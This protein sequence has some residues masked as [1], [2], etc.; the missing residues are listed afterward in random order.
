MVS[1]ELCQCKF[2]LR[3]VMVVLVVGGAERRAGMGE[4]SRR[5]LPHRGRAIGFALVFGQQLAV[6]HTAE[7]GCSTG[8]VH[9]SRRIQVDQVIV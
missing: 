7:R 5:W 2:E 4:G 1:Q 6:E 8:P 3:V 9:W